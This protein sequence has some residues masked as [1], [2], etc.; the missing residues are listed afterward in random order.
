MHYIEFL[1]ERLRE[2]AT[3]AEIIDL[4][5]WFNFT[6]FDIVGDL[7]WASP[8]AT[9]RRLGMTVGSPSSLHSSSWLLWL[10]HSGFSAFLE[11]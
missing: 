4:V 10:S 11:C 2:R 6:T 1:I 7:T 5:Q 9:S 3:S 8:L